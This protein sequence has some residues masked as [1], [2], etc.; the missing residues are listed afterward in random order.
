MS[1]QHGCFQGSP[2]SACRAVPQLPSQ[3]NHTVCQR[4][5]PRLGGVQYA[6]ILLVHLPQE[7]LWRRFDSPNQGAPKSA[8]DSTRL[9]CHSGLL[10]H[11]ED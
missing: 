9:R 4:I 10:P 6:I 1:L 3:M 8:P 7:T 5:V 11:G 2:T